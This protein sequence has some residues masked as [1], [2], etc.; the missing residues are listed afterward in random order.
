MIIIRTSDEIE[1]IRESSVIVA[2][3]LEAIRGEIKAGV[4]TRQLDVYAEELARQRGQAQLL[5]DIGG[6]LI[7]YVSL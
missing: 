4:T 2:D 5:R 1:K 3:V 6:I 7:A